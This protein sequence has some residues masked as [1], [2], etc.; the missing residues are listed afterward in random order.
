MAIFPNYQVILNADNLVKLR[1]KTV[2][3]L[4]DNQK[5]TVQAC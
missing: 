3:F 2:I 4:L 1:H 5:M